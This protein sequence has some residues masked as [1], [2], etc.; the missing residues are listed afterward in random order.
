[1]PAELFDYQL[2]GAAEMARHTRY[3]NFDEMGIGKTPQ[4]IRALDIRQARRGIVIAPA[5]VRSDWFRAFPKFQLQYR[6]VVKAKSIHDFM[7]WRRGLFD[8]LVCSFDHAVKW[9]K[10]VHD[11]CAPL[12]FVVIDEGHY[13]KEQTTARA[14]HIIGTQADGSG[15]IMWAKCVYWLTGT[16]IPNSP[17]DIWTFLRCMNVMPLREDQFCERYFSSY[18]MTYSTKHSAKNDMLSEIR[19]LIGNNSIRRSLAD[20]GVKLPPIHLTTE[21]V[22]GDDSAVRQLLKEHPGLDGAIIK[23]L[24]TDGHLPALL[25]G[26]NKHIMTLRRLIG[27]AKAVPYAA[28]LLEELHNGLDKAVVYGIHKEAIGNCQRWL[29]GR[30]IKTVRITGDVPEGDETNPKPGTRVWAIRQFNDDP[31]IRVFFGNIKAAGTGISLVGSASVDMLESDWNP[32]GN[33]QAIKRVH[34]IGQT[35]SVRARFISLA[36]SFDETVS[37]IVAR[38]SAEIAAIEGP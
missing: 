38:K 15:L 25:A 27:E 33:A 11:D 24:E 7:A 22:D 21:Y 4:S 12:D 31:T 2:I 20:S 6:S 17:K 18:E 5:A 9:A 28:R 14:S 3:G 23:A 10:Y 16:P 13:L 26:D 32:S 1:M 34:R 29:E 8:V 19:T 35:R 36:D 37:A 30:G